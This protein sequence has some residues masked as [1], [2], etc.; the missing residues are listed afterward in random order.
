M[1]LPE[2]LYRKA[3]PSEIQKSECSPD[4]RL[5]STECNILNNQIYQE[6]SFFAVLLE[7][8]VMKCLINSLI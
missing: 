2:S 7:C 5:R 6:P 1:V 8:T 4:I 3:D